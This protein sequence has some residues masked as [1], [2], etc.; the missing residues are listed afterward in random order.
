MGDLIRFDFK[1]RTRVDSPVPVFAAT[2]PK[3]T[4]ADPAADPAA[5]VPDAPRVG[6]KYDSNLD[7]VA[8]AKLVRADIKKAI[9]AGTISKSLKTSVR[10]SRYSM[11]CSL[12]VEI[13][14]ASF[15]IYNPA[16]LDWDINPET[17]HHSRPDLRELP[18]FTEEAIALR[19][20]L[21]ALV[22]S[23]HRD[24]SDSMTD[25][26]D[27]NFAAYVEFGG[28]SYRNELAARSATLIAL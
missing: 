8:I 2:A 14:S 22:K 24:N 25:Y 23:Y 19:K 6:S 18:R 7:V 28:D 9:K 13:K 16:W 27:V 21:E 11:G 3:V 26:Y 10:T 12:S 17:K 20:E 4:A 15:A 5:Y 1:A